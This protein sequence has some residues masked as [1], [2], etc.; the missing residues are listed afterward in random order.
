MVT[1]VS[2][3]LQDIAEKLIGRTCY[4]DWPFLVE[5]MVMSVADAAGK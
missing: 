5:A 1:G 3:T 4:V 2:Q